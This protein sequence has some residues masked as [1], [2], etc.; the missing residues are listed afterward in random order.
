M[1]KL[2]IM[3]HFSVMNFKNKPPIRA[4][5]GEWQP[6][7]HCASDGTRAHVNIGENSI[8]QRISG[9]APVQA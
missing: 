6:S 5:L 2:T 1:G 7:F 9:F 8:E 3:L 4:Q